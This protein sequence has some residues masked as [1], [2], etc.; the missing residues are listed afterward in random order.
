MTVHVGII[1]N[2]VVRI[3]LKHGFSL[4]MFLN[5]LVALTALRWL[6]LGV[7]VDRYSPLRVVDDF[8]SYAFVATA[9]VGVLY[10][11]LASLRVGGY[12]TRAMVS[13]GL[14]L[15]RRDI[16]VDF[17]GV[18]AISL[19]FVLI[20]EGAAARDNALACF[21]FYFAG[22]N[23]LCEVIVLFDVAVKEAIRCED[24]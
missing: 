21:C 8:L 3:L 14:R 17:A 24:S 4:F 15:T 11:V 2:P 16:G 22:F 10:V 19:A 12:G 1:D 7:N 5:T 20:G 23:L 13:R 9:C 18:V 6:L